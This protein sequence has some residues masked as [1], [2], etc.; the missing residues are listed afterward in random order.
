MFQ[1]NRSVNEEEQKPSV[2]NTTT[3]TVRGEDRMEAAQPSPC[4]KNLEWQFTV[5]GRIKRIK[6][7]GNG[8][9]LYQVSLS[10]HED[11]AYSA[12]SHSGT[13]TNRN[14]FFILR[15]SREISRT[16]PRTAET[17]SKGQA[18]LK[19]IQS[20][21]WDVTGGRDKQA[22]QGG[23]QGRRCERNQG[24]RAVLSQY[25]AIITITDA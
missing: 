21:K 5:H 11:N 25:E 18:L 22:G 10:A 14:L 17:N 20:E 7:C 24:L 1:P 13:D 23:R 2:Q 6:C 4:P 12:G 16:F 15:Q 8:R 19:R 3:E 9:C